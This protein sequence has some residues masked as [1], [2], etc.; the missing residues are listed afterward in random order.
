MR[1]GPQAQSGAAKADFGYHPVPEL[2]IL[3]PLNSM[4]DRSTM[5]R[6][7]LFDSAA[8]REQRKPL[9]LFLVQLALNALWTPLFFGLHWP[10][11]AFAEIILLWLAIAWTL[12]AFWRVHR[13][14][15][16]LL[17]PYLAWTGF[18]AVLDGT[19]WS[20]NP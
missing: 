17:A 3:E 18:A 20:V 14:A 19:L 2:K 7:A 1:D 13:A 5:T 16:L 15:A 6:E 4:H 11:G 8:Y 12:T 9:L 10:A